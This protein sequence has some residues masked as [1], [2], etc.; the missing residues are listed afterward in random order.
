VVF[1]IDQLKHTSTAHL[2]KASPAM[3]VKIGD[4]WYSSDETPIC[5]QVN[6]VEQQQIA[7]L[8]RSVAH[9]GKYAVFPE[10]VDMTRE[11]MIC[12]MQE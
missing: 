8:D 2:F 12:W 3:N 9:H 10:S 11:E 6:E 4:T 7:N 1:L 5:I